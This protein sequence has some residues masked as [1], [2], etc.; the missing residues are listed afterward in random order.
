MLGIC[1]WIVEP[2]TDPQRGELVNATPVLLTITAPGTME[3][4]TPLGAVITI[5]RHDGLRRYL[6]C[7]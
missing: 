7:A 3:L 2:L 6:L 4:A 1:L 5:A